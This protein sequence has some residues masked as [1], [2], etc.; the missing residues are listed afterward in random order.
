MIL[1]NLSL[2][3]ESQYSFIA[4]FSNDLDKFSRLKGQKEKTNEK[5]NVYNTASELCNDL[6]EIYFDEYYDLLYSKK[7]KMDP[8]C[9]PANLTLD[10]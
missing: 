5:A 10:E 2:S 4:S 1:K 8:K 9:D 7:S 3:L 6:L